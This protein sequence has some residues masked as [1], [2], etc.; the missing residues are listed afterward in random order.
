MKDNTTLIIIIS[1]LGI[2][3]FVGIGWLL[4]KI[5]KAKPTEIMHEASDTQGQN[6]ITQSGNPCDLPPRG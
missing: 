6:P 1:I 2:H 5:L 3:F 4:Y